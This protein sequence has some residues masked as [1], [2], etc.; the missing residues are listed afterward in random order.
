MMREYTNRE[1]TA[2]NLPYAAMILLGATTI[3]L[4]FRC[5]PWAMAGALAYAAAGLGG[6]LWIMIFV[7]PY[8]AYFDTRGCLCGY[9][10]IAARL[11][12]KGDRECFT[13]KFK[14]HIPVIVPLWIV[15]VVAGGMELARAFTWSLLVLVAA[16]AVNSYVILPLLSKRHSCGECPQREG[17]PWM[18]GTRA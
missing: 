11:A 10:T 3:S 13:Q 8:C 16:F 15:P 5:A 7:C 9:G 4:S 6:A 2:A 12:K 17:C 1:T 18:S 14:R